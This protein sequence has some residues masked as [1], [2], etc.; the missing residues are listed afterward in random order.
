[1]NTPYGWNISFLPIILLTRTSI[2]NR[3]GTRVR[4]TFMYG[5]R[6][7][8]TLHFV[9]ASK[10]PGMVFAVFIITPAAE[11]KKK[12]TPRRTIVSETAVTKHNRSLRE[13]SVVAGD[14]RFSCAG[15]K[16]RG[17]NKKQKRP[18]RNFRSVCVRVTLARRKIEPPAPR[19]VQSSYA[20]TGTSA[21][22][23]YR[24]AH[25]LVEQYPT[26]FLYVASLLYVLFF[27][28]DSP[29]RTPRRDIRSRDD[30]DFERKSLS[31]VFIHAVLA[32][33]FQLV[34]FCITIVLR[35]SLSF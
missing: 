1:V 15:G 12:K 10:R 28:F 2:K 5:R 32:N 35:I 24:H 29:R 23:L 26:D 11:C 14:S 9:R 33:N 34:Y 21:A 18:K 19:N 16:K 27:L 20:Y 13:N 8:R 6:G 3:R 22:I 7:R 31:R 30:D 25:Y 4:N 17:K